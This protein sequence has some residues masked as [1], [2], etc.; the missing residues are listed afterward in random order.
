MYVYIDGHKRERER[1]RDDVVIARQAFLEKLK[2]LESEH[3]PPPDASDVSPGE[4]LVK[5]GNPAASKHLVVICHDESTFQ[6]NDDQT[7]AWL[8]EDQQVII[9]KS[10]GSGQMVSDF[11]D[12]YCGFLRLTDLEFQTAKQSQ[13]TS[14]QEARVILEYRERQDG[15]WTNDKFFEQVKSAVAIANIKYP[16]EKYSILWFDQSSN[17]TT[18]SSDAL[19]T[20]RMNVNPGGGQPKMHDTVYEDDNRFVGQ[21]LVMDDGTPEGLKLVLEERG[22]DTRGKT[23]KDLI[24]KLETYSDFSNELYYRTLHERAWPPLHVSTQIP[25]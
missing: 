9:S 8:Q 20:N 5:L 7:S 22:F 11:V 16:Q 10:R 24:M 18:K 1:E 23:R 21:R 6:S 4:Q 19:V 3:L 15:Y 12:E 17:H 25:L 2:K 13:P 14:K